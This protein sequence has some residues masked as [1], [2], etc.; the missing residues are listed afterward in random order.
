MG[1]P[2]LLQNRANFSDSMAAATARDWLAE[3][4]PA[5]YYGRTCAKSCD[6]SPRVWQLSWARVTSPKCA[7]AD[8]GIAR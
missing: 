3:H 5:Y 6:S 4:Q 1:S 7:S 2:D 8:I